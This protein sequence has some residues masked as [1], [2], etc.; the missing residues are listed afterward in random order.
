MELIH[1]VFEPQGKEP[2]PTILAL[3]GWGANCQDLLGLAPH[4]CGGRFLVICPQ[5]ALEM[6]IG[7]GI[8]G[9]G[10]F[11]LR[12]GGPADIP[13]ILSARKQLKAF[14]DACATRYPIDPNKLIVLGF[15]QG[16]V[17]AYSLALGEPERFSAVAVLSSWL[18]KEFVNTFTNLAGSQHPPTLIQHGTH[19]ELI[20]VNRARESVEIARNLRIPVTYREYNMG[21]EIS[22]RSLADLSAWL[23]EKVLSPIVMAV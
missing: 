11:P 21:H 1:A 22:Q 13:A 17:M 15:S 5:G 4:L 6:E 9:Y 10:W 18:S 3:H 23:E 14:L 20:E 7:P 8:T 2:H 16:G 19:D 12:S